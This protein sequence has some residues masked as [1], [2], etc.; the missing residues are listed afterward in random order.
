MDVAIQIKSPAAAASAAATAVA[1]AAA[2]AAAAVAAVA[3]VSAATAAAAAGPNH[4][5]AV[6]GL[7]VVVV[8]VEVPQAQTCQ[9][10]E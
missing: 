4:S 3:A 10:L 9:I 1:A 6:L 2:A 7:C 8:G 5:S